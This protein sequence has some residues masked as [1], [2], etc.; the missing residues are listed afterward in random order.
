MADRRLDVEPECK[1]PAQP[2]RVLNHFEPA[3]LVRQTPYRVQ[4]FSNTMLPWNYCPHDW[5]NQAGVVITV[6]R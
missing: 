3:F 6:A 2:W 4:Q 5:V 1:L